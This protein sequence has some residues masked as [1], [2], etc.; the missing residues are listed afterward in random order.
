MKKKINFLDKPE[1]PINFG[2]SPSDENEVFQTI[3]Q[4]MPSIK[5]KVWKFWVKNNT[6]TD[7]PW[8]IRDIDT[9]FAKLM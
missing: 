2:L 1:K 5:R 4:G 3:N 9:T 6:F 7:I 8:C